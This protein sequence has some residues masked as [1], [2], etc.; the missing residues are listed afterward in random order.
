LLD[1]VDADEEECKG[2]ASS[3]DNTAV[4]EADV[5]SAEEAA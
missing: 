4:V 1:D 3:T 5:E 2:Q